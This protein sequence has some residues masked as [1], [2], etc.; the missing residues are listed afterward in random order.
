MAVRKII[1]EYGEKA[2]VIE[3]P[4]KTHALRPGSL[5]AQPDWN[6]ILR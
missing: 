5:G 6:D 1:D 4:C 2:C 3:D